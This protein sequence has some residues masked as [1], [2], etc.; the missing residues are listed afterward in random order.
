MRAFVVVDLGFGDAGKGIL[1]DFL[2]RRFGAGLV[3]RYN[4][5]AQAGH[6]V[7][8]PDVRHHTFS[9]FGSGTFVPN[10]RTYLS[11]HVIIDPLALL[12]E[13]NLLEAKGVPDVF[14]RLQI[15]DQALV[16]TPFQRAANRIREL[17]RGA[18]RHGSCGMG[19][20]ETF[21]DALEY[22]QLSIITKDIRHPSVLREKLKAI[23][24]LKLEQL[25]LFC[26]SLAFDPSSTRD[27]EAFEDVD[28]VDKWIEA[29][30]RLD[31]PGLIV[32]SLVQI[33]PTV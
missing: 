10:V 32:S 7:V 28:L 5:G 1:T 14:S 2:V 26:K 27:F 19:V 16:I 25:A 12:V 29:V 23:R 17:A 21:E 15:S 33:H 8:T 11:R 6:N 13:G 4:G 31:K 3:V 22:P 9:Q 30:T 20:G 24:A 18:N